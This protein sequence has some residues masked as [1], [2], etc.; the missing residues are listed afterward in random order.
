[1]T[2]G[3]PSEPDTSPPPGD[4][5]SPSSA[6]TEGAPE[7]TDLADLVDRLS[8]FD[9]D[10]INRRLDAL[11]GGKTGGANP[12]AIRDVF[13]PMLEDMGKTLKDT[14]DA[15]KK[16]FGS[17]AKPSEPSPGK[18]QPPDV[19]AQPPEDSTQKPPTGSLLSALS[20]VPKIG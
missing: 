5:D 13:Q 20:D 7:D 10:E 8:R 9:P 16:L 14:G 1:V 17:Q 18:D 11:E 12:D 3:T 6:G 15:I 4:D 2:D 19:G